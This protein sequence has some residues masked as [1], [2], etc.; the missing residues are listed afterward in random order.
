MSETKSKVNWTID[1][2]IIAAIK[3]RVDIVS[4]ETGMKVSESAIANKLLKERLEELTPVIIKG[5]R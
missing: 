5:S 4:R 1:K 3:R 2:S